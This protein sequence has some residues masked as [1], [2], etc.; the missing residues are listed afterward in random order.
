MGVLDTVSPITSLNRIRSVS[1]CD[2]PG[3]Y[4]SL[5]ELSAETI[6]SEYVQYLKI[7]GSQ[8]NEIKTLLDK[9]Q[10]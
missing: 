6:I 4:K 8:K 3:K 9:Y 10:L 5:R 1:S 7:I 2:S